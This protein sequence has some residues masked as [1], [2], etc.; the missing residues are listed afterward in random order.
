MT[1]SPK[2][3]RAGHSCQPRTLREAWYCQ[4]HHSAMR[5][6]EIARFLGIKASTLADAVNPDGDGSMLAASHHERALELT[7]DNHAV[8]RYVAG[9]GGAVVF[10][11]PAEVTIDESTAKVVKEFGEMLT[12]H[13]EARA[14]KVMTRLEAAAFRV[15]AEQSIAATMALVHAAEREAELGPQ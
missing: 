9:L 12:K 11:L 2:Q 1:Q 8:A 15:E 3:C 13:A 10:I 6:D 4:I 5:L 7:P 14:D